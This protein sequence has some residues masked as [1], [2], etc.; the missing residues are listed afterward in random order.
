M[1]TS[2][3]LITIIHRHV[4]F[5]HAWFVYHC[6]PLFTFIHRC[7]RYPKWGILGS[8]QAGQRLYYLLGSD[9]YGKKSIISGTRFRSGIKSDED[10]NCSGVWSTVR[11]G[12]YRTAKR[13]SWRR[14]Y[15]APGGTSPEP[16]SVNFRQWQERR[17]IIGMCVGCLLVL[18]YILLAMSLYVW[19]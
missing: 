7:I 6:P 12:R 11:R 5:C 10:G 8:R 19:H 4:I 14:D 1:R 17:I 16:A 9:I 2:L 3:P 18:F 15:E 13:V